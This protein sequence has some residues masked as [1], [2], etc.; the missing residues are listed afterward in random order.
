MI[1]FDTSALIKKYVA[2][3]GSEK[4][5][6]LVA[7]ETAR[8]TSKLTFAETCA[9]LAR[10]K[11]EGGL[12]DRHHRAALNSYLQDWE[13]FVQVELLDDL[14][15]IVRRLVETYPLRGA[16]AV[17]LASAIWIRDKIGEAVTFAASDKV[18]NAAATGE[19]FRVFDPVAE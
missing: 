19:G 5:R 1:Y 6:S 10:K 7:K 13:T 15:P 14:L 18:L 4:I 16:D 17:H 12:E 11:R 3:P 2:E 8:Y 9:S